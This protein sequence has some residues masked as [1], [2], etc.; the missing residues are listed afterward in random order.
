MLRLRL[1]DVYTQQ[2]TDNLHGEI[3]ELSRRVQNVE[4][5][6]A[7]SQGAM[8]QL[9]SNVE[10]VRIQLGT[11]NMNR[12]IMTT[13]VQQNTSGAG[14]GGGLTV[15]D[16]LTAIATLLHSTRMAV[17]QVQ[18]SVGILEKNI[19]T[20]Q[21]DDRIK[22]LQT[23]LTEIQKNIAA[24]QGTKE[25]ISQIE[26]GLNQ[27]KETVSNGSKDQG[28]TTP[29]PVHSKTEEKSKPKPDNKEHQGTG[30]TTHPG[31]GAEKPA[32]KKEDHPAGKDKK[33]A[34]KETKPAGKESK[35]GEKEKQPEDKKSTDKD[36]HPTEK[37][38]TPSNSANK[39]TSKTTPS[40]KRPK[41][42]PEG[43]TNKTTALTPSTPTHHETER[44]APPTESL[45]C[46]CSEVP[47]TRSG[48]YRIRLKNGQTTYVNC[49]LET[50]SNKW[51]VVMHRNDGSINFFRN[52][53]EYKN[54]FGNIYN[55]F[56]IGLDKLY[57]VC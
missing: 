7:L 57:Q 26:K 18:K 12:C 28:K 44:S 33:P 24:L 32:A 31:S 17:D 39:T 56:W 30:N 51:T 45:P 1:M 22:Q 46:S 2:Q 16:K 50:N 47:G 40:T 38:K 25:Q 37:P 10:H 52:W 35:P 15:D 6:T 29:S 5:V 36:K 54:G 23:G 48:I 41:T 19:T 21:S 34:D 55:E 49:D 8:T 53:L 11:H 13:P 20:Y 42:L 27:L 14:A 9:T 3:K 43:K 4:T